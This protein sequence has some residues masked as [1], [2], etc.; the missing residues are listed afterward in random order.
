M[1]RG[2]EI[3]RADGI[4]ASSSDF[5][6]FLIGDGWGLEWSRGALGVGWIFRWV[7][8]DRGETNFDGFPPTGVEDCGHHRGIFQIIFRFSR[9]SIEECFSDR[10]GGLLQSWHQENRFREIGN[11]FCGVVRESD[12]WG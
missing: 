1:G 11:Q 3:A 10:S 12:I 8:L 4:V 2:R 7:E 5:F 9:M 6:E